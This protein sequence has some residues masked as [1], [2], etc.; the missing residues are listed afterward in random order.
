M[1]YHRTIATRNRAWTYNNE[2]PNIA[3]GGITPQQKLATGA[4]LYF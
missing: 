2:R 3:L 1:S 4:E